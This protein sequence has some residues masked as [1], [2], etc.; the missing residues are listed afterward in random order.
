MAMSK[1]VETECDSWQDRI[2]SSN[3]SDTKKLWYKRL[4]NRTAEGT[5]GLSKDEKL[6]SVSVSVF[7]LCEVTIAESLELERKFS[8]LDNK[9][10]TKFDQISKDIE[11]KFKKMA[12]LHEMQLAEINTK[13]DHAIK[14][15]PPIWGV[16]E[17]S[18]WAIVV[19]I[20]IIGFLLIIHPDLGSIL[21]GLVK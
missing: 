6:Q 18:K 21:A 19:A 3:I 20:G 13:L 4:L 7:D 12:E 9:L 16:I 8:T 14:K 1:Q 10:T 17:R 15:N 5:N 2:D 11:V